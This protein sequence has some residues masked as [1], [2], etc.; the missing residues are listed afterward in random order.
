MFAFLQESE[1]AIFGTLLHSFRKVSFLINNGRSCGR[2][3]NLFRSFNNLNHL[4]SELLVPYNF[5]VSKLWS[6]FF[7]REHLA[8]LGTN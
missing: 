8:I 5:Y 4:A 7:M 3:Q 6:Y 1:L 2:Q